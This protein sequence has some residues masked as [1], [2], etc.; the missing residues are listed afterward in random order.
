MN[1]IIIIAGNTSLPAELNDNSTAQQI[2]A[3]SRDRGRFIV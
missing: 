2:W 1:R 3:S